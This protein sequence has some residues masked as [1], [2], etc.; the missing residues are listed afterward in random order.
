MQPKKEGWYSAQM[1]DD[2]IRTSHNGFSDIPVL[3]ENDC[4]FFRN[5]PKKLKL[6]V[7]AQLRGLGYPPLTAYSA[8]S[9][10]VKNL[11]APSIA[12]TAPVRRLE[13]E[14]E[15][16]HAVT[17]FQALLG[18]TREDVIA[19]MLDAVHASQTAMEMVVAWREIGRLIGA[20]NTPL[21]EQSPTS[22]SLLKQL[23]SMSDA[24]LLKIAQP[25][26]PRPTDD[27]STAPIDASPSS[28]LYFDLV[29]ERVPG[30][31]DSPG[32]GVKGNRKT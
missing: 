18:L 23:S 25:A 30:D 13:A 21:I 28:E 7:Y 11:D 15:V 8:I 22:S 19:G 32:T 14:P 4:G 9:K 17:K 2:T 12:S 29:A 26:L 24:D 3:P 27:N 6:A 10:E 16:I 20:Y 31:D 1:P 5:Q